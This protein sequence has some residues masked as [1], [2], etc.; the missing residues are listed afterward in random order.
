MNGHG[1]SEAK[2]QKVLGGGSCAWPS[3]LCVLCE[4][5]SGKDE[6]GVPAGA[7]RGQSQEWGREDD[8]NLSS[9][10]RYRGNRIHTHTHT[11]TQVIPIHTHVCLYYLK[12]HAHLSR[13]NNLYT[14]TQPSER[15]VFICGSYEPWEDKKDKQINH[16]RSEILLPVGFLFAPA[17]PRL[18]EARETRTP[19][20]T[21]RT[22][23]AEHPGTLK[24]AQHEPP[25]AQ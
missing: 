10:C 19:S 13:P 25:H 14:R 4:A 17:A 6:E 15:S 3:I 5:A 24:F 8:D 9:V 1:G 11:R 16:L 22:A 20:C 7:P 23:T 21:P 18:E 12:E 2:S